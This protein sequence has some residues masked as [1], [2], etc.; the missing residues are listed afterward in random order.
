[1]TPDATNFFFGESE[2]DAFKR[3][4]LT[5]EFRSAVNKKEV[6]C[7]DKDLLVATI[8]IGCSF[9]CSRVWWRR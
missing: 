7:R 1:M 6:K 5:F 8:G 4:E 3:G 2:R 9:T